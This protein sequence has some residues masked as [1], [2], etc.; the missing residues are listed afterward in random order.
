[1][2]IDLV[3]TP[4][5]FLGGKIAHSV[6]HWKDLSGDPWIAQVLSGKVIEL[7]NLPDQGDI[8]RPLQLSD[9]D[10]ASLDTA[11][12]QFITHSIVE[13]CPEVEGPYFYSN[14]F[15]RPKP[16]GSS[17][18][19]LNLK[20]LNVH[21]DKVHFKMDTFKEV[22]NLVFE[23][24][25]FTSV[26]FKHAY[27]SVAVNPDDR[28]WLRFVWRDS[29]YQFTCLP[30]GLTSAPRIFTKLLKPVLSHLRTM[31]IIILCYID[32]CIIIADSPSELLIHTEYAIK[33]FDRLG[34]TVHPSKSSFTPSQVI[35][36]LGFIIDSRKMTVSLPPKKQDKI[37]D[38][39]SALLASP[40]TTIRDLASFIGNVVAADPA[41][42]LGPL[43]YKYIEIVK[44]RHLSLNRGNYDAKCVL[45]PE[46]LA[47]IQWWQDNIHLQLKSIAKPEFF[48][49]LFTDAS[50]LGW[51][52]KIGSTTTGGE[53]SEEDQAHINILELKAVLFGLKS[54]CHNM[55][56]EH[57]RVRSDNTTT[58][59]CIERCSSTKV[60][61]LSLT[62][63]IFLWASQ[64]NISLSAVHIRGIDN[65]DADTASRSFNDDTEWMI[66]PHVFRQLCELFTRPCI[67]L[68][69][70]RINAQLPSYFSWR[71]DPMA[72][73]TNAFTCR[74]DY[75]LHY[76]FPPF[77]VIGRT[78]H[79]IE[80]EKANVLLVVPL[81]PTQ[82]WF[83]RALKMLVDTPVLLP[84]RC[85]FLPQDPG[86]QHSLNKLVLAVLPLSGIHSRVK[87]YRRR[88]P[89]FSWAPGDRGHTD[90]M[91]RISR[92]GCRFASSG[93]LIHFPHL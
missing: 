11:M 63:Q 34:L 89:I 36:F 70:T 38:M 67:D 92:N 54:L 26:D 2:G 21:M 6:S 44:N 46:E 27:Y 42:P 1:M 19:I 66:D 93:R 14:I 51:G 50:L 3:N 72:K 43:R 32:D 82:P 88:L 64:N 15:P 68:F 13:P 83:P 30:Q 20:M 52:A 25:F 47:H 55:P 53:W 69:A 78:L 45:Q 77:S 60:Q 48:T 56:N 35:E 61:L 39:A 87:S 76:A 28:R 22:T 8:P 71:P 85:L 4:D 7:V 10:Q 17:R 65:V 79:K 41:V 49:E 29:H 80:M 5:N 37:K 12:A 58:V 75:H 62:E 9:D 16:D 91:G 74:W 40:C 31:G 23:N 84:R 57:I 81:W 86:K 24:C 90:N 18:V 33:L 59:A 73:A